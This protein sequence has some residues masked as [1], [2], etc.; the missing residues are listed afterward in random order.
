MR[1]PTILG[2][3]RAAAELKRPTASP[4]VANLRRSTRRGQLLG[5]RR[6][7][8]VDSPPE[9]RLPPIFLVVRPLRLGL[10]GRT[11]SLA[12]DMAR[13]LLFLVRHG[14]TD[15]NVAGRWQGHTDIAL[16]ERGREQAR[17]VAERLRDVSL[18]GI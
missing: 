16:N 12:N 10:L 8:C 11:T 18:A 9:N 1:R 13:R 17:I 6:G 14:E 15:W 5:G 3:G 4:M 7:A 2:K